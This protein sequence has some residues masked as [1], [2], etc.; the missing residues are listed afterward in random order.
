VFNRPASSSVEQLPDYSVYDGRTDYELGLTDTP[1][2]PFERTDYQYGLTDV[3]DD[4]G[5]LSRDL[6]ALQTH[7]TSPRLLG[8]ENGLSIWPQ[9]TPGGR[10]LEGLPLEKVTGLPKPSSGRVS[11]KQLLD[12]G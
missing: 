6:Y 9:G 1:D 3:P 2:D 11:A 4:E 5:D 7:Q 12:L 8:R 10:G